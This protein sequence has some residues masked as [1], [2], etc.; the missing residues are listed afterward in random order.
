MSPPQDVSEAHFRLSAQIYHS[1]KGDVLRRAGNPTQGDIFIGCLFSEEFQTTSQQKKKRYVPLFGGEG[2]ATNIKALAKVKVTYSGCWPTR[3]CGLNRE[4][5]SIFFHHSLPEHHT[6]VNTTHK[7]KLRRVGINSTCISCSHSGAAE[8]PSQ[9]SLWSPLGTSRTCSSC[10]SLICCHLWANAAILL[11]CVWCNSLDIEDTTLVA[12]N[13]PIQRGGH[14]VLPVLRRYRRKD[15]GKQKRQDCMLQK[16]TV[17]G[18]DGRSF[19]KY[20]GLRF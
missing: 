14:M 20:E 9:V 11:C 12:N 4:G 13:D 5:G 2:R 19:C 1:D 18:D 7:N 15:A 3:G 6:R 8:H 17:K 16:V 10:T